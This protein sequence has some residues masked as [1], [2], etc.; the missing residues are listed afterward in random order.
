MRFLRKSRRPRALAGSTAVLLCL[1]G[2]L[3]VAD[4]GRPAN[5]SATR[6]VLLLAPYLWGPDLKGAVGFGPVK[7]S[8]D[9]DARELAS[10]VNAAAMGYLRYSCDEHFVYV[11]GL[12]FRFEDDKFEPFFNQSIE[13]E[14]A[15]VEAGYGRH[16]SFETLWPA[17][18]ATVVSP[19]VGL[20]HVHLNVAVINSQQPLEANERWL[21]PSLGVIVMGPLHRRFTYALKFDAAGFGLGRDHYWSSITAVQ[22]PFGDAWTIGAGYRI[23]RFSAKPEGGN[24]LKL[25]LRG[26]GPEVGLTYSFRY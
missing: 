25:N 21:D 18:G 17:K 2:G 14:L 7:I 11:E 8:L 26:A 1:C 24:D 16:F 23:S 13:A 5:E 15:S 19:Y 10:G 6:N 22:Y 9:V 3:A 12:G 20:R 4:E